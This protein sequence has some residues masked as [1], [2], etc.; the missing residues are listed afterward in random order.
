MAWFPVKVGSTLAPSI[1]P[2]VSASVLRYNAWVAGTRFP[3]RG[4]TPYGA[5]SRG[6][7]SALL[8]PSCRN[9]RAGRIPG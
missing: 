1:R 9:R 8:P 5:E 2:F 7:V 4:C 3:G 6:V